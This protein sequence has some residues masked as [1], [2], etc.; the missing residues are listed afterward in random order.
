MPRFLSEVAVQGDLLQHPAVRAWRRLRPEHHEPNSVHILKQYKTGNAGKSAVY[1]LAG[2]G[3]NGSPVVAKRCQMDAALVEQAVYQDFLPRLPVSHLQYYGL[4]EEPEGNVCW[5][6]LEDAKGDAYSAEVAEHRA[7]AGRWLGLLHT[8]AQDVETAVRLPERESHHHR[9]QLR[10]AYRSIQDSLTNRALRVDDRKVL[11]RILSYLEELE[12]QW[13]Q[14]ESLCGVMPSTLVHSDFSGKNIRLQTNHR[15]VEVLAFDWESA[16]W[17]YAAADLAQSPPGLER[18]SANPDIDAY[19]QV[20]RDAWSDIARDEIEQFVQV[21]T[22]LRMVT[23]IK[24]VAS[25]LSFEWI[26][27]PMIHLREYEAR[28]ADALEAL[29]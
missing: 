19:W 9:S 13:R 22:L 4:V 28:L 14:L 12:V 1:R 3:H 20:A 11:P 8:G 25:G 17:G 10:S 5:L 15:E 29:K 2:V 6:F 18:F 16:G 24:W 23:A 7:A 21:G 27:R 26:Q